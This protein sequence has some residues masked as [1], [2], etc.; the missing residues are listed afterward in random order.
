MPPHVDAGAG[1]WVSQR[2]DKVLAGSKPRSKSDFAVGQMD[3]GNHSA[4]GDRESC[5]CTSG[6]DR[7]ESPRAL[8]N[9]IENVKEFHNYICI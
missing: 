5:D 9:K 1:L 8:K 6:T 4:L 7:I 2:K 3:G